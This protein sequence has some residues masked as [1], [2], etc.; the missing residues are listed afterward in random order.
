MRMKE[1]SS[2]EFRSLVKRV[3]S[4]IAMEALADAP[5]KQVEIETPVAKTVQPLL[6][7]DDPVVVPI[8]RAGIGMLEGVTSFIPNARVGVLGMERDKETHVAF[9]YY[10]K[11]PAPIDNT[12]VLLIDPM[13]ATG[14]TA[15]DCVSLL[16]DRGAKD[17][18]FLCIVA[19]P[20]GLQR[21]T[22]A[23]PDVP[24]YVGAL[25]ECLNEKAYI[26]PGL[27]DA[28]DRI[29]DTLECIR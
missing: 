5:L 27:G 13:L 11:L 26:V 1:T 12:P 21:F 15:V 17:I 16:K 6:E 25:D 29:F 23:H 4:I 18:R 10:C 20:E 19:A 24:V 2:Y 7:C 22:E 9:S 14:G 3:A 28:G 8:L